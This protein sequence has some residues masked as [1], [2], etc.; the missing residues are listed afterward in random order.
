MD[1]SLLSV[2]VAIIGAIFIFFAVASQSSSSS[3][4]KYQNNDCTFGYNLSSEESQ[5]AVIIA[6]GILIIPFSLSSVFILIH[7][8]QIALFLTLVGFLIMMLAAIIT[9]IS[10]A[11]RVPYDFLSVVMLLPALIVV[12]TAISLF[13]YSEKLRKR[14]LR[15]NPHPRNP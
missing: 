3:I 14:F 6:G 12:I 2:N 5:I 10:L 9:T 8:K 13:K 11:C 7:F 1:Y 4:L 15:F